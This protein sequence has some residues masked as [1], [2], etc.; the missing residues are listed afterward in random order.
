MHGMIDKPTAKT[1]FKALNSLFFFFF[2]YVMIQ[3]I[4]HD[5]IKKGI[6][7]LNGSVQ[8]CIGPSHIPVKLK[9]LHLMNKSFSD[10]F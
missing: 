9:L 3:N 7:K 2:V 10:F 4:K 5:A 6:N 8:F 1:K